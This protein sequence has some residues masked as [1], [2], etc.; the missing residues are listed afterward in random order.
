MSISPPRGMPKG[1]R[2]F[3]FAPGNHAR[4]VEKVFTA[5]ADAVILDLEDAVPVAE[6]EQTRELVVAAMQRARVSLGYVRINGVGTRWCMGDVES[7]IGPW[8]D[9]IVV[10]KVE[11]P[12]QLRLI[13][14]KI[15]DAERRFGLPGGS[16][17]LMPIIETALGIESARDIAAAG[18]RVRRLAFGGGDYTTE[19]DI[20]WTAEE[21]ELAYARARLT[22]ASRIA[23]IEPPIDTVCV[24]VKDAER[25]RQSAWN[26]R[27]AGFAGK[28][29]I[30]PD[31]VAPCNEVYAPSLEEIERARRIVE[32]FESA[33]S[34]GSASIR[35]DG[36]FVDYPIVER[37]RRVLALAARISPAP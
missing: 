26:G 29:C 36:E 23:G 19:L 17:D 34:G 32:A 30:H 2:S 3:L 31:Q 21:H 8:L 28:L 25:F 22:H 20:I 5:G 7:V 12:D 37:A 11:S 14:E 1:L 13:S 4:R 18:P 6:K 27:R 15:S 9:G 10:P 16:I 35:V 24:Q 33:E